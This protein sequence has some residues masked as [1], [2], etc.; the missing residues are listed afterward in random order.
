MPRIT[1]SFYK[2]FEE[3]LEVAEFAEKNLHYN[4]WLSFL[5]YYHLVCRT[6]GITYKKHIQSSVIGV[7]KGYNYIYHLFLLK[8]YCIF[9]S[10]KGEWDEDSLWNYVAY[11][12][13]TIPE[14]HWYLVKREDDEDG[15]PE[16]F[17][18]FY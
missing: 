6:K 11:Q 4:H 8:E 14:R 17:F 12:V 1:R 10:A 13:E 16:K 7:E 2:F 5:I 18:K 3:D 15:P 9:A